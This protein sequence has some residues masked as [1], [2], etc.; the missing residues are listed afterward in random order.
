MA[1]HLAESSKCVGATAIVF[2]EESLQQPDLPAMRNEE[3]FELENLGLARLRNLQNEPEHPNGTEAGEKSLASRPV[4]EALGTILPLARVT[5]AKSDLR[6]VKYLTCEPM[7]ESDEKQS[8]LFL[9]LLC[10]LNSLVVTED[11][12]GICEYFRSE[13]KEVAKD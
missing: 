7:V 13:M 2:N 6:V 5:H 11:V 3:T 10:S 9:E 12:K 1:E 8:E 4:E